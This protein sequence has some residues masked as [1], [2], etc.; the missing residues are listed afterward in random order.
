MLQRNK[1][2]AFQ[3]RTVREPYD[4]RMVVK[5]VC[6]SVGCGGGPAMPNSHGPRAS[7]CVPIIRVVPISKQ[8]QF[9]F[10]P[11]VTCNNGESHRTGECGID[12]LDVNFSELQFV[13][14]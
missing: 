13:V 4:G 11:I 9:K 6:T 10:G 14:A 3:R 2:V 8:L 7:K 5:P 12:N 1:N